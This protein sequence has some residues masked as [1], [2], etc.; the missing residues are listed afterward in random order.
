[1][2]NIGEDGVERVVHQGWMTPNSYNAVKGRG[3]L[4]GSEGG[5]GLDIDDMPI[6]NADGSIRG[7]RASVPANTPAGE[8]P[9]VRAA[10]GQAPLQERKR[11]FKLR[12]KRKR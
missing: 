8:R 11:H 9:L 12:I 1:M 10:R 5:P 2:V 6:L 4:L 3:K 7:G